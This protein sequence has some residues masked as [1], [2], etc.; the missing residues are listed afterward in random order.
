MQLRRILLLF[1]LVLGLSAVVAALAPPPEDEPERTEEPVL[2]GAAATGV[3]RRELRMSAR[4]GRREPATR[5]AETGSRVTLAV[6][7][8]QPGDIEIERLGLRQAADPR[9]PARFE[10]LARPEGR[11]GVLFHPLRGRPRLV[12]R[13]VFAEA[14]TVKRRRRQR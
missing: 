14:A 13:L 10:L 7:V 2:E 12:G 3:E 1:A 4:E 6:A 5:R 8:P 11:F 9:A